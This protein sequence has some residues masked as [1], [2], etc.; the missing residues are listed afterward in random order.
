M[1]CEIQAKRNKR[2]V[3]STVGQCGESCSGKK[4]FSPKRSVFTNHR[5]GELHSHCLSSQ[6][7]CICSFFFP[8][9]FHTSFHLLSAFCF[10]LNLHFLISFSNCSF[11]FSKLLLSFSFFFLCLFLCCHC[12]WVFFSFDSPHVCSLFSVCVCETVHNLH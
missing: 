2:N 8:V 5:L 10:S 6:H 12:V 11:F 4:T 9:A 3:F 1:W 7:E